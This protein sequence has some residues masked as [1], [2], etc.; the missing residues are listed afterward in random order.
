MISRIGF[1]LAI[2]T[3]ANVVYFWIN[4]KP[5][6]NA[7]FGYEKLR[8]EL[9]SSLFR[10]MAC[11]MTEY[12]RSDS[13]LKYSSPDKLAAFSNRKLVHEIKVFFP[14]WHA[15]ITGATNV[16]RPDSNLD[17]SIN[18]I[19]LATSAIALLR[20][21]RMS[22]HAKRVSTVPICYFACF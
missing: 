16:H 13:M 20:N 3:M 11:E 9:F 15:C 5:V 7:M 4:W 14:L 1:F 18:S 22:A 6:V 19:A 10:N 2:S 17:G 8:E 12:I 21:S